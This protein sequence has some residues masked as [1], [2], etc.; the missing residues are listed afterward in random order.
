MPPLRLSPNDFAAT[1]ESA[2]MRSRRRSCVVGALAATPAVLAAVV[3]APATREA[4][5]APKVLVLA[6]ERSSPER[7]A[8]WC[9]LPQRSLLALFPGASPEPLGAQANSLASQFVSGLKT[10]SV[11]LPPESLCVLVRT[12]GGPWTAVAGDASRLRDL[13][14]G[15]RECEPQEASVEVRATFAREVRFRAAFASIDTGI[16]FRSSE[17]AGQTIRCRAFGWELPPVALSEPGPADFVSLLFRER[18]EFAVAVEAAGGDEVVIASVAY[19][20]SVQLTWDHVRMQSERSAR[21]PIL[22]VRGHRRLAIPE[23]A[24]GVSADLPELAG[25]TFKLEDGRPIRVRSIEQQVRFCLDRV[26]ATVE[27]MAA[28]TVEQS[29]H[30]PEPVDL[31]FSRP[32]LLALRRSASDAPYFLLWVAEPGL[33]VPMRRPLG[34]A[35]VGDGRSE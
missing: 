12:H 27:T 11:G 20:G 30:Q 5:H 35:H 15:P 1:P 17:S 13:L 31:E 23:I 14:P 3:L 33:L 2:G 21:S 16:M 9:P 25:V 7:S 6:S 24:L 8:V 32:F 29:E 26:G 22:G 28:L 18:G 4:P 10:H 34:E 19:R